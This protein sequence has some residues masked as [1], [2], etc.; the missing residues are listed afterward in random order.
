MAQ[1]PPAHATG[2]PLKRPI[3]KTGELLHAVG[4]GTWQTFDVSG[5]AAG[6]AAAREVLA[7]FV[8]AGGQMV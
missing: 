8:K 4:L 5:D 1:I 3:P 6:L 2:A 7:R